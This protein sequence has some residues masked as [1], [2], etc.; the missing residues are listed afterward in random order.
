MHE[1]WREMFNK[2]ERFQKR[3]VQVQVSLIAIE[4]WKMGRLLDKEDPHSLASH[5]FDAMLLDLS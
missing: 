4:L 5:S 1:R 3:C 2:I